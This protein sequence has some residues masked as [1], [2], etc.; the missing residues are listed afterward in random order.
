MDSNTET[1]TKTAAVSQNDGM[2]VKKKL[3]SLIGGYLTP[4]HWQK[5]AERLLGMDEVTFARYREELETSHC[6]EHGEGHL[7][8]RLTAPEREG[9]GAIGCDR[10]LAYHEADAKHR[11]NQP[12]SDDVDWEK[13]LG[14]IVWSRFA[15][16]D[17]PAVKSID[18]NDPEIRE[19]C[20]KVEK[21]MQEDAESYLE[22]QDEHQEIEDRFDVLTIDYFARNPVASPPPTTEKLNQ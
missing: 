2:V 9:L 15:G 7:E 18:R 3:L 17:P 5:K 1:E 20:D 16:G 11:V 19:L 12:R 22:L 6:I 8:G 21:Q 4:E 10:R 14:L 13:R